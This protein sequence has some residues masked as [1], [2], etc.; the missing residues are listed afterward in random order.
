MTIKKQAIFVRQC[1]FDPKIYE[2]SS[3]RSAPDEKPTEQRKGISIKKHK[4]GASRLPPLSESG[5][6]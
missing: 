4:E 6:S 5:D 2:V 3:G 1:H